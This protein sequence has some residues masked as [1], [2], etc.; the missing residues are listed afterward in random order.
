MVVCSRSQSFAD[1]RSR[2]QQFVDLCGFATTFTYLSGT[3]WMAGSWRFDT[4]SQVSWPHR[5]QVSLHFV[6]PKSSSFWFGRV[7]S[8][9]NHRWH[10]HIGTYVAFMI[11]YLLQFYLIMSFVAFYQTFVAIRCRLWRSAA[12]RSDPWFCTYLHRFIGDWLLSCV[13]KISC[14]RSSHLTW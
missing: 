10:T 11:P 4:L 1:V 13:L 5:T 7:G 14:L 2:S 6:R 12:V 3:G 9:L 8:T